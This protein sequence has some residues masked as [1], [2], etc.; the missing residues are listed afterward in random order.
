MDCHSYGFLVELYDAQ[1]DMIREYTLT[2]Y[3]PL[4]GPMQVALYD[5]KNR[6]QF[7]KRME[8][9]N[10]SLQDLHV[11]N[12]VT[13]YARHFKV[14]KYAD[15]NTKQVMESLHNCLML[16]T[17]PSML[18]QLGAVLELTE[19]A[20][21]RLV[22]MRLINHGGQRVILKVAGSEAEN[23]W[24]SI[25]ASLPPDAVQQ[26]DPEDIDTFFDRARFPATATYNNCALCLI[27]PHILKD[28]GYGRMVGE[29]QKAGFEISAA[30]MVHLQRSE[31]TELFDV[32]KEV[33]PY[34]LKSIEQLCAGPAIALELRAPNGAVLP[35]REL[36]GPHDT[37]IA[38]HI[39]PNSLRAMFGK[40]SAQ[41]GVHCTDLE[42]D[43]DLECQYIFDAVLNNQ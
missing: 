4:G 10:L 26:V 29:I 15:K 27:R 34:Y 12:T 14:T 36:C 8:I 40:D 30:E 21:L 7:L 18:S 20:G 3:E 35:F 42:E 5:M 41:N 43:G 39:R 17:A 37:D 6:R 1:A 2:A 32:Y 38:R 24:A 22:R 23:R 19:Q 9:P 16:M 11:G 33:L 31:A 28:G 25:A 13:V